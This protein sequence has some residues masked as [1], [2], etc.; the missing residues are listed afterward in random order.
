MRALRKHFAEL[1]LSYASVLTSC[2]GYQRMAQSLCQV[3]AETEFYFR[4]RLH[5]SQKSAF[6]LL[7][8]RNWRPCP[9]VWARPGTL[10]PGR[11]APICRTER[12]RL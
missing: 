3:A 10:V 12:S 9:Q 11:L 7:H 4:V 1:G 2:R 8:L 6:N 5:L